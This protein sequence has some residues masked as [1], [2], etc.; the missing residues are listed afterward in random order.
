MSEALADLL[1]LPLAWKRVRA[2]NAERVFVKHPYEIMLA[3]HDLEGWLHRIDHQIRSGAYGPESLSICDVPKAHAGTRPGGCL[4][5]D[6]Q[7][8]YAACVGACIPHI[9][10]VVQSQGRAVD[11]SYRLPD[12]ANAPKWFGNRFGYWKQYDAESL[13]RL[14]EGVSYVV[15]TDI[16]GYYE[17]IDIGI[18]MS[19]L[20]DSGVPE[21]IISQLHK[22]LSRWSQSLIPGRGIP[23][24]FGASDVLGKLYLAAVDRWL[25]DLGYLHYRYVDDYRIFCGSRPEAKRALADLSHA[26]RS[27]GLVLQSAKSTVHRAD[28]ARDTIEMVERILQPIRKQYKSQI[29][30]VFGAQDPYF[31][32]WQADALVAESENDA[33][34]QAIR[35]AYG[36]HVLDL[37]A[38][39]NKTVFRFL[40]GRLGKA[41]DTFAVDHC[42]EMLAQQP[43]ETESILK[44]FERAGVV[45]DVQDRMVKYLGSEDAVYPY[46]AYQIVAWRNR[47][48]FLPSSELLGLVRRWVFEG[49]APKYL[50]AACRE[51]LARF[52]SRV[53]A[54]RMAV[55]FADIRDD[56][57]KAE[58]V[59]SM[60]QMETSRRN[61]FYARIKMDGEYTARA[62]GVVKS[63]T[64][65]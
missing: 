42:V 41:G 62:I 16:A 63:G 9:R 1:D 27:R 35:D 31:P 38:P 36:T 64:L 21:E 13:E 45:A 33:P 25:I 47:L 12:A 60:R 30:E 8:V 18:L 6:D 57:E 11:F 24:G 55:A 14:N 2:D 56:F 61:G 5:L 44:Y 65:G 59:C 4:T 52:G 40:L 23:Q 15:T 7:V 10:A 37:T 22:C 48:G 19:D 46:Q 26:L 20:R 29:A 39:F 34:I 3:E 43:Q 53:D 32:I 49:Q 51:F 50:L 17:N 54:N 28:Q 58:V